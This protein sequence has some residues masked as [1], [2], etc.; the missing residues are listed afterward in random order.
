MITF[1]IP[2]FNR[3]RYLSPLVESIYASNLTEFE[4]LIIEDKSPEREQIRDEARN[5]KEKF[6]D[7]ARTIR[8]IENHENKGYDKN[9]K[10]IIN[11]A[12]GGVIIF[13]GNDDLANPTELNVYAKEIK[14]NPEADVFLRGYSTFDDVNGEVSSTRIVHSSRLANQENDLATLYRFSAIISGFGVRKIFAQR[15]ELDIFDGGLYY[16]IYLVMAAF[17]HTGVYISATRPVCC[18]RD[19]PPEF[20]SSSNEPDFVSGSYKVAAR[21]RMISSQLAIAEYFSP[22]HDAS[23]MHDFRNAMSQN[24]APHLS[25]LQINKWRDMPVIYTYLI[26]K[27]IGRNLRSLVIFAILLLFN[28]TQSARILNRISNTFKL[29]TAR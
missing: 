9:L 11:N 20:G 22:H 3:A 18:R 12:R 26:S 23:F 17:T 27:G 13:F 2:S 25:E 16:Q 14:E 6:D 28:K 7:G 21:K 5:L 24:I 15:L 29:S 19:I 10:E 1:G 4:V 8:Y